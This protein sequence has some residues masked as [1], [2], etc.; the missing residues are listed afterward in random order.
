MP[1]IAV[2]MLR[3]QETHAQSLLE[4]AMH[5]LACKSS[6][7]LYTDVAYRNL[8]KISPP[9]K[10]SPPPSLAKSY[11]KGSLLFKSTPTLQTRLATILRLIRVTLKSEKVTAVIT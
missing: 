4:K 6:A 9:S 7:T 2:M 1:C 8:P 5:P 3:L 10:I 11:C